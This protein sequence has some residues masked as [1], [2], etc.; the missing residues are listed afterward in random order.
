MGIKQGSFSG[1]RLVESPMAGAGRNLAS[2]MEDK[3][4]EPIIELTVFKPGF[5]HVLEGA[6]RSEIKV[7]EPMDGGDEA[8]G[9]SHFDLAK[10][11]IEFHL[12]QHETA[13]A[14]AER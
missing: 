11:S 12:P 13:H 9:S 6:V 14:V 2:S 10:V 1:Q 7:P 5:L 3:L 8:G 4:R